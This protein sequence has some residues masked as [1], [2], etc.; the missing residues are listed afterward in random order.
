MICDML[1]AR[2]EFVDLGGCVRFPARA[3]MPERHL[4]LGTLLYFWM[5]VCVLWKDPEAYH[6]CDY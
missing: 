3:D 1:W 2:Y 4:I 5:C 6:L